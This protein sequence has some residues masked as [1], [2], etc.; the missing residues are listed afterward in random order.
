MNGDSKHEMPSKRL[1]EIVDQTLGAGLAADKETYT[2]AVCAAVA[3]P[4]HFV[5][6]A[7]DGTAVFFDIRR[8]AHSQQI[9]HNIRSLV[10]D[11][12]RAFL[13]D[14]HA[15]GAI[16]GIL[17]VAVH[18]DLDCLFWVP[19]GL[20]S[21]TGPLAFADPRIMQ[22]GATDEPCSVEQLRCT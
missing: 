13:M 15:A 19:A 10:D 8:S 4:A 17:I 11:E 2:L 14:A 12:R 16:A 3:E 5:G 18:P 1:C 9:T 21:L 22:L 7:L 20:L 6:V